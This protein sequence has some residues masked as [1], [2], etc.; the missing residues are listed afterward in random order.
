MIHS[1]RKGRVPPPYGNVILTSGSFA[2]NEARRLN[3][4]EADGDG[5]SREDSSQVLEKYDYD[6]ERVGAGDRNL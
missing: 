2:C 3:V 1:A 4:E 5:W 6:I